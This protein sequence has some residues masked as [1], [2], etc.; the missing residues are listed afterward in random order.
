[1]IAWE[2]EPVVLTAAEALTPVEPKKR[3]ATD[4]AA[5]FLLDLLANGAMEVSKIQ[6]EVERAGVSEKTLRLARERLGVK[7]KRIGAKDGYWMWALPIH[8]DALIS[9]VALP[10]TEGTLGGAGHLRSG[11]ATESSAQG[12]MSAEEE[13]DSIPDDK[14]PNGSSPPHGADDG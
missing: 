7:S 13:V 10:K 5:D 12:D 11:E 4:D 2:S 14:N 9:E 8:E 6:E 3:T 1:M